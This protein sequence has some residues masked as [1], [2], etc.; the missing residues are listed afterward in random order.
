MK[1]TAKIIQ[2]RLRQLAG[3]QG[4]LDDRHG[5][6]VVDDHLRRRDA[7]RQLLQDGLR[8]RHDLRLRRCDVDRRLEVDLDDAVA[9]HRL[10]LDML[11][12]VD[13]R[14]QHALVDGGDAALHVVR[15]QAGVAPDDRNDRECRC[16]GRC[17]WG[18][19]RSTGRRTGRSG[20]TSPRRCRVE[21]ARDERWRPWE[22]CITPYR[23]EVAAPPSAQRLSSRSL[24]PWPSKH[25]AVV[26]PGLPARHCALPPP[27]PSPWRASG[28]GSASCARSRHWSRSA[29]RR[30][31]G[32]ACRRCRSS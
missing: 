16:S 26:S 27:A 14:R 3:G 2:R 4:E 6:R 21:R 18:S 23:G 8:D 24:G 28:R 17:R 13:R 29:P 32:G 22:V 19:E 25:R 20:S 1:F 5:G 12:V 31:R 15:R 9:R 11:D 30:R 10:R 7:G